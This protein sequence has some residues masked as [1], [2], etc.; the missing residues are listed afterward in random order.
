[1]NLL[2]NRKPPRLGAKG[3]KALR[4]TLVASLFS[5]FAL[6]SAAA[7]SAADSPFDTSETGAA[8]EPAP[9]S[10]PERAPP[11]PQC[12]AEPCLEKPPPEKP[13]SKKPRRK[14]REPVA[15]A[16]D[17]AGHAKAPRRASRAPH[18][19]VTVPPLYTCDKDDELEDAPQPLDFTDKLRLNIGPELS[20]AVW[21]ANDW[22]IG[23]EVSLVPFMSKSVT[24]LGVLT[25]YAYDWTTEAHRVSGGLELG[26]GPVGFQATLDWYL[27]DGES[28]RTT[29]VGVFVIV[30]AWYTR[31][32]YKAACCTN[33]S[34]K[35][36]NLRSCA[37]DQTLHSTY[38]AP[39]ARL[40]FGDTNQDVGRE[41]QWVPFIGIA[42]KY[43]VGL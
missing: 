25:S 16:L 21:K 7:P 34:D 40:E 35:R 2:T 14:T 11:T 6:T 23:G 17:S 19:L 42:G 43:G 18:P 39:F 20:R 15:P 27:R 5:C 24:W 9:A 36:K 3:R 26:K 8:V 28:S 4:A 1:M 38:L 30:P 29:T 37:C 31:P 41:A 32:D 13:R 22:T 33:Y 12:D 10:A